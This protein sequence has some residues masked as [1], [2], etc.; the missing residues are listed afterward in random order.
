MSEYKLSPEDHNKVFDSIKAH[1]WPKSQS[2]AQ[3]LAVITGGQPGSG[4]SGLA[5]AAKARMREQGGFVL[6]DADKMRDF[7]PLYL[8]AQKL[9]DKNAADLTHPD[10]GAW[11]DRLTREAVA[12]KRNVII[13]QTS[14]DPESFAAMAKSL[15]ENGYRVEAH[16]MATHPE[17]SEQR[18]VTRYETQKAESGFGRF[19]NKDKHDAALEGLGK[20]VAAVEAGK[21]ADS[22]ALYNSSHQKI[23]GNTLENGEW[24]STPNAGEAFQR[25]T[26]RPMRPLE[27]KDVAKAY[28]QAIDL[29]K[30][31]GA[32]AAAISDMQAKA[33]A[34]APATKSKTIGL[35][36]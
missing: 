22:I 1:Y 8:Q 35:S 25:E 34:I 32:P 31:R 26:K 28:E 10:A 16:F 29:M 7:H 5:N 9:H 2:V 17:V 12:D 4:K 13:D 30:Q 15:K 36:R 11:A 6:V 27:A 18:I 3:P 19:S 14:R 21:L 23:Y 24:K 33:K 20:T